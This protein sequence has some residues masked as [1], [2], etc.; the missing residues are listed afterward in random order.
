MPL[1]LPNILIILFLLL[2]FVIA[3][4]NM[5][6]LHNLRNYKKLIVYPRISVLI[7]ARNE[8]DN[9]G[10]CVQS[11]L[12]QDYPNFEVL[13][14]NDNSTDRTF[15]ILRALKEQDNRLKIITGKPLPHGWLGKHW[16]CQQLYLE[17]DG[18]I[19]MF[20]DA[21]TVHSPDT[22]RCATS[23]MLEEN[24]DMISIIPRHRLVTWAEKLI[25]PMFALGVYAIVPLPG[26]FRPKKHMMLSS[27]GK[28]MMF[29]RKS[30]EV[31]GGFES[32]K[33]CVLDDLE[34]PQKIMA[35]GMHY[36]LFDG[37]DN[38]SCRMYH[39]FREVYQGLT[40]NIFAAY[41][42]NVP[43][44]ILTW[45]WVIF[46]FWEPIVV[47]AIYKIPGYPPPFPIGLA[48][49]AIIATLLLWIIYFQRFKLP[50]YLAIF[51]PISVLLMA[52]VSTSSMILT[53]S[54]RATWKDRKM[55]SRKAY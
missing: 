5:S 38:V 19:I 14:L 53:L 13:V 25:M 18:Q 40:K 45:L 37:T 6:S 36:R 23:A 10:T 8:E 46:A 7:P 47:L 3:T 43:V 20:T 4:I 33:Q 51:Y 30:Y 11:L 17:S 39:N 31:A 48:T 15:A 50:V 55:P 54:G 27:S 49:I 52:A 41:G 44:F 42:Y 28:L 16:A 26:R 34:L 24:A 32:I 12:A 29:R 35:A 21:D 1:L 22:L 9:I 2:L